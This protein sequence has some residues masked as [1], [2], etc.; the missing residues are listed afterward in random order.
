M[1]RIKPGQL[2]NALG[3]T[4]DALR[5]QRMRDTSPYEYEVIE[6]RVLYDLDTL[7][8]VVRDNI[9]KTTTKKTRESHYDIKSPRYWNSISKVNDRKIR[10]R[11]R[12]IEA[13]VKDRLALE[14]E[15]RITK[16]EHKPKK[17][18]AYFIN[19]NNVRPNWQPINQP[20]KKKD[21]FGYY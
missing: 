13:E 17:V 1:N 4:T 11:K 3:I 18:Y 20:E 21:K 16:Q 15:K 10:N 14:H 7:P 8:Q 5:K 2:A 19:C 6:G 12:S 9:V